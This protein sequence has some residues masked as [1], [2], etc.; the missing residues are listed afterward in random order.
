MI[1]N[2]ISDTCILIEEEYHIFQENLLSLSCSEKPC[3]KFSYGVS[4]WWG[5]GSASE[6]GIHHLGQILCEIGDI[7]AALSYCQSFC[8]FVHVPSAC[9]GHDCS[10]YIHSRGPWTWLPASYWYHATHPSV[11]TLEMHTSYR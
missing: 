10:A 4:L 1:S 8:D 6:T 11:V 9:L 7:P 5:C 2:P 3:T